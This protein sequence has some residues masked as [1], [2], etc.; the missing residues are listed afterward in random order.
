MDKFLSIQFIAL[1]CIF[2]LFIYT[3]YLIR[4]NKLSAH[5][6]VSWVM[7]ELLLGLLLCIKQLP[8]ILMQILGGKNIYAIA[9]I[10]I[11]GWIILLMLDTLTRVSELTKKTRSV[12]EENG[13]LRERVDCLEEILRKSKIN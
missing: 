9:I 13:L 10:F 12:I 8:E 5:L 3:I 7:M 11:V 6:A 2:V 4:I 1:A